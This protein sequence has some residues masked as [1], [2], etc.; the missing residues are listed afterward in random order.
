MLD[1][2]WFA[3]KVHS[4]SQ[5]TNRPEQDVS[6]AICDVSSDKLITVIISY[7]VGSLDFV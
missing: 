5:Q 7:T 1:I 4:I 3:L 6:V 2:T